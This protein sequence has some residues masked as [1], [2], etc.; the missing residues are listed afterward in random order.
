M[1]EG[2]MPAMEAICSATVGG[3]ELLGVSDI[4]GS[5]EKGK[6]ADIVAVNGDPVK[7]ISVM[8][9]M[10]FVMKDGVIYKSK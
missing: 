1:V 8:E 6:L 9:K 2:G 4:L 5:I 3:A 7:D 10:I